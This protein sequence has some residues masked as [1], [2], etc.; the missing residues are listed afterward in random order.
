VEY[1]NGRKEFAR[2]RSEASREKL[3]KKRNDEAKF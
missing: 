2:I 1:A 3:R